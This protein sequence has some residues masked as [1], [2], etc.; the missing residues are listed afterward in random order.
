[1]HRGLVSVLGG[2]AV[3]AAT[4][5]VPAP[6]PA[7]AVEVWPGMTRHGV[8]V[9]SGYKNEAVNLFWRKGT[10][11]FRVRVIVPAQAGRS[12]RVY[13]TVFKAPDFAYRVGKCGTDGTC[14]EPWVNPWF[15]GAKLDGSKGAELI[16]TTED[17]EVS[18]HYVVLT[19]QGGKLKAE[20]APARPKGK[21]WFTTIDEVD[22]QQGYR[23][24]TLKK[25]R[26][27]DAVYLTSTNPS[28]TLF[29]G[30][31]IRSVWKSGK[32]VKTKTFQVHNWSSDQVDR[33]AGFSGVKVRTGK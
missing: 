28:A 4:L 25:K 17:T 29:A 26:Y 23:F 19:Y 18:A 20:K 16:F 7:Q 27:V 2:V 24:F 31:V 21:G 15:G 33:Y 10:P 14:K 6:A 30:T 12:K 11:T 5:V 22:V 3:V 8:D 9:V 32:W 13:S 1:M